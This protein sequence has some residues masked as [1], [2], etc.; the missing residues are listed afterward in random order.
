M[1]ATLRAVGGYNEGLPGQSSYFINLIDENQRRMEARVMRALRGQA[2]PQERPAK[3]QR[4]HRLLEPAR[5]VEQDA[6][7]R[8]GK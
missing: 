4:F 6:V 1:G 3:P 7:H 2:G 8:C 5:S